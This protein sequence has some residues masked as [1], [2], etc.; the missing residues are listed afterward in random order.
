VGPD[1]DSTR[2]T[3]EQQRGAAARSRRRPRTRRCLVKGCEQRFRPR[4]A[5]ERYCSEA[6]RQ[7]AR[8]W[9][10]RKAQQSYRATAAGK[11]KRNGQSRRYRERVKKRRQA[12]RKEAV[13]EPARVITPRFFRPMLRPAR[14]LSRVPR[15]AAFAQPALLFARVPARDGTS[16]ATR[17]ALA[18][19]D[20]TAMED[21]KTPCAR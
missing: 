7:A 15:A 17:A 18:T 19:P 2:P 1:E 6:C 5:R 20:A 21:L 4:G 13:A 14:L 16:L 3:E 12:S 10:R 8:E 9:S 11:E